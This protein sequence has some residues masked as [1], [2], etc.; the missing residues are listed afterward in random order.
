MKGSYLAGP[1]TWS[2]PA[3]TAS[4]LDAA[5]ILLSPAPR[6]LRTDHARLTASGRRTGPPREPWSPWA[7]RR[8]D[9]VLQ[10]RTTGTLPRAEMGTTSVT[11]VVR[12][13]G[14]RRRVP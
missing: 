14:E 10:T 9:L 11:P 8:P 12:E 1:H 3:S 7:H 5:H 4:F 13:S 2:A 6:P